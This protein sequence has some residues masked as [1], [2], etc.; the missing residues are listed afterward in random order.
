MDDHFYAL[1]QEFR[2]QFL[3]QTGQDIVFVHIPVLGIPYPVLDLGSVPAAAPAADVA[4][5]PAADVAAAGYAH[6]E[7]S[8]ESEEYWAWLAFITAK[9]EELIKTTG[10]VGSQEVRIYIPHKCWGLWMTITWYENLCWAL[11][12]Q[13]IPLSKTL[14]VRDMEIKYKMD[15]YLH[16]PDEEKDAFEQGN[17]PPHDE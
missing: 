8:N 7:F 4:A 16:L 10:I 15:Q 9:G 1:Q 5:A 3:E 17:A 13:P 14:T 11:K 6:E 2:Q 12:G